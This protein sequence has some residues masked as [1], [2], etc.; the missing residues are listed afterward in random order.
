MNIMSKVT[1]RQMRINRRRTIVTIIGVII[2]VAM[3]TAVST[4]GGS[5]LNFM[6]EAV[7]LSTGDY[8]MRYEDITADGFRLLQ[9][10]KN[11]D[12][13][14]AVRQEWAQLPDQS[15]DMRFIALSGVSTDKMEQAG[16]KLL[17]GRLPANNTELVIQKN[18]RDENGKDYRIGD[19]I[20]LSVGE[21]VLIEPEERG[22]GELH[23]DLRYQE[24][25]RE[26]E[27]MFRVTEQRTYTIVG[28]A[29]MTPLGDSYLAS[30]V[31]VTAIRPEITA[32]TFHAYVKMKTLDS[33]IYDRSEELAE[34]IG[35][36]GARANTSLLLYTGVNSDDGFMRMIY[37]LVGILFTIIFIGSVALIYNAFAISVTERSANFG[38]L[39]SVGATRR[40]KRLAVFFEAFVIE[41]IAIP[42]GVI[43][44]IFGMQAV[45]W[46][47]NPTIASMLADEFESAP[48]SLQ[49]MVSPYSILIAVVLSI[50]TVLFRRGSLLCGPAGSHQWRLFARQRTSS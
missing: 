15:G 44:G 11:T 41:L 29:A 8:H 12:S 37:T 31:V 16:V 2:S 21:R 24:G 30:N 46:T 13:A 9:S 36:T 43:G 4:L 47:V 1:L 23:T 19:R 26:G 39:A 7:I 20:T 25:Y 33:S 17:E 49:V 28:F 45:F 34:Q 27:E 10:D 50:V 48:I 5:F 22:D 42:L 14:Y 18:M 3:F 40:Q 32:G 38:L 35:A 6:Q